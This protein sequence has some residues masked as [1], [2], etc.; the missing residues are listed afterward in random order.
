[1]FIASLSDYD[2]YL[3][4]DEI[5]GTQSTQVAVNRL[6]EALDLF[7]TTINWKKTMF[8]SL[9]DSRGKEVR[10][11]HSELLFKNVGIAL[12]LNKK[13]LFEKKILCSPLKTCFAEV[14]DTRYH[15]DTIVDAANNFIAKKFT[16]HLESDR[17]FYCYFTFAL[18]RNSMEIV[19]QA[20]RLTIGVTN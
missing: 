10:R 5:R 14:D 13:D 3:T 8:V 17:D 7:R 1:M 15:P 16:E 19:I 18:D 11:E 9:K 6:H 4:R 20:V 2:L 12:F